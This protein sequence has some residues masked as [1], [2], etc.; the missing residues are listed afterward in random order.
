[1]VR[2]ALLGLVCLGLG[3]TETTQLIVAVDTDFEVPAEL[4]RIDAYSLRSDGTSSGVLS[5]D[6]TSQPVPFSFGVAPKSGDEDL[7]ITIVVEGHAGAALRV[8]A[9]ARTGFVRGE[10]RRLPIFLAKDCVGVPC[11][12]EQ[13]CSA[14]A[15]VSDEVP[16]ES[17]A[18]YDPSTE[19]DVPRKDAGVVQDGGEPDTG[20]PEDAGIDD[21]GGPPDTGCDPVL[22]EPTLRTVVPLAFTPDLPLLA[23]DLDGDSVVEITAASSTGEVAVIDFGECA[24][25]NVVL[26]NRTP[27]PLVQAP[28]SR[29]GRWFLV[30]PN[31]I[32]R[33]T[34]DGTITP[35]G[36]PF[37]DAPTVHGLMF[38]NDEGLATTNDGGWQYVRVDFETGPM[39]TYAAPE[40]P[41]SFGV[42]YF[43]GAFLH[44]DASS[45]QRI[46]TDVSEFLDVPNVSQL[47]VVGDDED[48]LVAG[49][50]GADSLIIIRIEDGAIANTSSVAFPSAI[51]AGPM[52][53]ERQDEVRLTVILENGTL[54]GCQLVIDENGCT[55]FDE[56]RAIGAGRVSPDLE[57]ISIG[58]DGNPWPDTIYA[59]TEGRIHFVRGDAA[60]Q[61]AANAV[62]LG[63]PASA[64]GAGVVDFFVPLG[65]SGHLLAVPQA[66]GVAI[67]GWNGGTAGDGW[68]QHRADEERSGRL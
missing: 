60:E 26:L 38:R 14:G 50:L 66:S 8:A 65:L 51:I 39:G 30:Q 63:S 62:D 24:E 34:Y 52:P 41:V 59:D 55:P 45:I 29:E 3:C 21:D 40:A 36:A 15:C 27:E 22:D 10:S 6:L 16:P 35:D 2:S 11:A 23:A 56:T 18:P 57:T 48:G 54:T 53:A 5:W 42:D 47:L 28:L 1:M 19:L 13:T 46:R 64:T 17:L 7:Q 49:R 68:S 61:D 9:T 37:V 67:I 32:E 33:L 25:P 31:E 12:D 20:V 44:A 4:D 58:I 43:D